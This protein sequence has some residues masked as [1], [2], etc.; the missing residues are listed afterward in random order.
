MD[1]ALYK[2][3]GAASHSHN[4]VL[5]GDFNHSVICWRDNTAGHQK[6]KR[7]LKSTGY[8]FLFQ[9]VQEPTRRGAMLNLVLTNKKGLVTAGGVKGNLGCTDHK[10]VGFKILRASKSVCSKF[11]TPCFRRA[12]LELF[13]KLLGRVP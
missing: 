3:I 4:M 10:M 11:A 9:V 13:I 12:D 5:I 2:H 6:P 1:E 8:I 7:F